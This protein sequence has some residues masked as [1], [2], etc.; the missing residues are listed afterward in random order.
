MIERNSSTL[1]HA[2]QNL[3][4]YAPPENSWNAIESEMAFFER[5]A[6]LRRAARRLPEYAPPP[7]VWES[8]SQEIHQP[9]LRKVYARIR[10]YRW[11]AAA[12]LLLAVYSAMF[13]YEQQGKPKVEYLVSAETGSLGPNAS[14][15][16]QDEEAIQEVQS[17]FVQYHQQYNDAQ[18]NE[19]LAELNELNAAC[20]ELRDVLDKYG[21]DKDLAQELTKAE[22]ERT[23]VVRKMAAVL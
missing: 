17:L 9:V 16:P 5:E 22:L 12:T 4:E 13:L 10:P 19:L 2:I 14:L 20:E 3:R 1:K 7:S 6:A 11:A 18:G 21:F 15:P 23:G 8:I